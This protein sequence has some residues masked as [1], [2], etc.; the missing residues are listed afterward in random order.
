MKKVL[1]ILAVGALALL[2]AG[3][4]SS[5][6][7]VDLETKTGNQ[8]VQ[9]A[10]LKGKVESYP[11]LIAVNTTQ[12]ADLKREIEGYSP[13]IAGNST[14]I[15][16]LE[17]QIATYPA[18]IASN[19][20]QI[21]AIE[22]R[23][24][25]YPALIDANAKDIVELEREIADYSAQIAGSA[26]QLADLKRQVDS[27]AS[28]TVSNTAL[29]VNSAAQLAELG[30]QVDALQALTQAQA[31]KVAALE[32]QVAAFPALVDKSAARIALQEDR[33][34]ELATRL[35][36]YPALIEASTLRLARLEEEVQTYPAQI[37]EQSAEVGDLKAR[38]DEVAAQVE[39]LAVSSFK[40]AYLEP[41]GAFSVFTD[42]VADLLQ[43]QAA[44]E[45][46]LAMLNEGFT[47]GAIT[48]TDYEKKVK[49]LGAEIL[50]AQFAVDLGLLEKLV[51]SPGFADL[52]AD[53]GAL[54]EKAA[55]LAEDIARFVERVSTQ[56]IDSTTF[57]D[58][59]NALEA[60]RAAL[61]GR[62]SEL[63]WTK[64]LE[65]AERVAREKGY[66]LV[67]RR[68]DILVNGNTGRLFDITDLV[69]S[70]IASQL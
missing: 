56:A 50:Q 25:G 57:A 63:G 68:E 40:V 60:R 46:E 55:P 1:C 14:R 6:R 42:T 29:I 36:T 53:L 39:A 7:L 27:Q 31:A 61:D 54:K 4:G 52:A 11:A 17:R 44:K 58:E 69:R 9:I 66:D 21:A 47:S 62:L 64:A 35:D 18:M 70:E 12:I 19:A 22:K 23:I 37:A 28:M 16:D 43:T 3:C 45:A 15:A 34:S 24:E 2:V 41:Q 38:L 49:E 33:V 13:L 8:A 59:K 51:A 67:L 10:E 65:I 20:T 26:A 32:A 30:R 5:K 48:E